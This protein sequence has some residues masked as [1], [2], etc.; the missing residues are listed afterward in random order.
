MSKFL[1]TFLFIGILFLASSFSSFKRHKIYLE[2]IEVSIEDTTFTL[3]KL[4]VI[5]G[6]DSLIYD[7]NK[8]HK[9]IQIDTAENLSLSLLGKNDTLEIH[10]LKQTFE[11]RE[12][13]SLRIEIPKNFDYCYYLTYFGS[14]GGYEYGAWCTMKNKPSMIIDE[15]KKCIVVYVGSNYY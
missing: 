13:F 1:F 5:K 4:L 7:L 12:N 15:T 8:K 2:R 9:P 10:D 3:K 14:Y 6:Q 11:E